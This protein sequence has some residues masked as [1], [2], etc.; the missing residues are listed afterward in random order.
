LLGNSIALAHAKDRFSDGRFATAGTGV[1]DYSHYLA[2]LERSGFRGDL[3]THGLAASEA[4]GVAAFLKSE[5]A[6]VESCR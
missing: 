3:I 2:V 5:I 6:A 1:L 4:E